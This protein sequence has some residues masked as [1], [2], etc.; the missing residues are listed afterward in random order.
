AVL[1]IT[2][3]QGVGSMQWDLTA[4]SDA[5]VIPSLFGRKPQAKGTLGTAEHALPLRSTALEV[6]YYLNARYWWAYIH[7]TAVQLFERQW[8]INLIFWGKYARLR[9]AVG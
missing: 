6:P 3:C 1:V 7:P 2:R 4:Q 9:D 8:L 5:A